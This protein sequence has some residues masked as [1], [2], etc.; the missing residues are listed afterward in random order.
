MAYQ[1]QKSEMQHC[2]DL[3]KQCHDICLKTALTDCLRVGGKHVEEE[4]FRLMLNCAEI[5]Q[6]AANFMLSNSALH[7]LV[8]ATCSEVCNACAASCEQ[9]GH[10]DECVQVCRHCAESCEEMAHVYSLRQSN[11]RPSGVPPLMHS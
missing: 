9:I 1:I 2:I 6:T 11:K 7:N 10:M 8:C 4:H 5:C 3:C